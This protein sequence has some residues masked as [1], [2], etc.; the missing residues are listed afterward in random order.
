MDQ[1]RPLEGDRAHYDLL[2]TALTDMAISMGKKLL[3]FICPT[4]EPYTWYGV[5]IGIPVPWWL[6]E[7]SAL[8]SPSRV[9]CHPS[10]TQLLPE[11]WSLLNIMLLILI[12]FKGNAFCQEI[13]VCCSG[14]Q[15]SILN[16][17]PRPVCF[18]KFLICSLPKAKGVH[19]TTSD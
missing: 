3:K 9:P 19:S 11:K 17:L 6:Y 10:Q 5:V 16:P 2:V 8:C 12:N 15:K 7:Y 1:G 18:M 14:V 4:R 13:D